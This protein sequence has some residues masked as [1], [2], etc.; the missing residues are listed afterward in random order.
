[1]AETYDIR[2]HGSMIA[3]RVRMDAY[4]AALEAAVRPGCVVLDVGTGLG[5]FALLACRLGARHVYAIDPGDAVHLA[6]AAARTA[7]YE[8]RITFIQGLSTE[9]E[10]PERAEVMVSDLRG[11]IPLFEQH[12]PSLMDA[13]ERL[14][15]PDAI[16]VPRADAIRA[17][18]VE[19][20]EEY[21][22]I[23]A[24]WDEHARGFDLAAARRC[25]VNTWM[26]ARL[27]AAQLVA[28]AQTLARLDYRTIAGPDVEG[29]L[30][31]TAAR[32]GTAHGIALWFD[33]ELGDG[34]GFS[35]GP[36]APETIYGHAFLPWPR[37]VPLAAGDRVRVEMRARLVGSDYVW[38]W[39]TRVDR[40]DGSRE[41]HRQSTL[42]SQPF[43]AETLRRRAHDHRPVLGE[44]GRIDLA[45]LGMM[46]GGATL[47]EVARELRRR[48][49]ARFARWEEALARAGRL[50]QTYGEGG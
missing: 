47:E 38:V 50:S 43:S 3:D 1:V 12:L 20:P 21:A 8:H 18:P 44:Q 6:R 32:A 10:L 48:F 46:E 7:G 41:E 23:T 11:V 19:A 29:T 26:R 30:E 34:I 36:G 25:A 39:N 22:R 24:P 16:L 5:M 4:A 14:L 31:W 28:P 45:A 27:A 37:P 40:G 13:R 35:T 2:G 17:A 49:P 15:V 33:A 9:T 42:L